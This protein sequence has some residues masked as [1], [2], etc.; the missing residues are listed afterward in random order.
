MATR[1]TP[2]AKRGKA[3]AKARAKPAPRRAAVAAA[4]AKAKT[5]TPKQRRFAD[6]Y[7]IDQNATQAATRAGYSEKTAY[8]IGHELLSKPEIQAAI[9]LAMDQRAQ[10][11]QIDADFV[12]NGIAKNIRRCEQAEPVLDRKGEQVFT[13]TPSGTLAAAFRYDATNTLRGYELLGKHLKLFTDKVELTGANGGAIETRSSEMTP[14]QRREEIKR[15]LAENPA[16]I[17]HVNP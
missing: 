12:L 5:L 17:Q 10:R 11:T 13:G 2:A 14:E 16:L 6:E 3:K 4:T 8:S 9:Q 7:L 15:L 1:K